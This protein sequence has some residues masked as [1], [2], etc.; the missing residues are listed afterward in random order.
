MLGPERALAGDF[1]GQL[2]DPFL[3]EHPARP[4]AVNKLL[5]FGPVSP[6]PVQSSFAAL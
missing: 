4:C 2:D 3:S 1:G 5:Y 6:Y